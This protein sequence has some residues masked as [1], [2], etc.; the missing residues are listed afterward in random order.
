MKFKSIRTPL[1][2]VLIFLAVAPLFAL[3]AVVFFQ[4]RQMQ[5]A[6]TA[7]SLKMAYTDLDHTLMG[8]IGMLDVENATLHQSL[9]ANLNVARDRLERVGKPEFSAETVRWEAKNQ[10]SGE[11]AAI[12]LPRMSVG[13]TWLGQNADKS[14]PTPIVDEIRSL[15][16]CA[17][18]IFQRINGQGDMLRVATNVETL[19]GRR[20]IGTF[21]PAVGAGGNADAVVASVLRGERYVGRA[22]VVNAWYQAAYDPLYGADGSVAGMLFVGVKQDSTGKIREQ[23]IKTR[24]GKTGYVFVLDT[25]GSYVISQDGK[26]DGERIWD[27]KD[28]GGRFFIQEMIS[29]AVALK[30]GETAEQTYSWQNPGDPAPREKTVR[31]GYFQPW[32]WVIGAGSYTDEFMESTRN[33]QSIGARGNLFILLA[34]AISIVLSAG[35]SIAFTAWF[36]RPIV[37]TMNMLQRTAEGDLDAKMGER[38][39]LRRD[40]IGR[41]VGA[42]R[43]MAQILS[44]ITAG[45]KSIADNVAEGAGR[46]SEGAQAMS[47]SASMQASLGQQVSASMEEMGSN[48]RQN[49]E[50]AVQTSKVALKAADDVREG[51]KTVS[52]T[53][54]AMKEIA[55]KTVII[56]EIARQ[57]NL[58]ALNAAIEAARAGEHGKGFAVVAAEVRKLAERSQS[59]AA[60]I[61]QLSQTSVAVSE[62]AGLQLSAIVADMRKTADLV[63]E[64][65]SASSEQNTGAEQINKAIVQLDEAIQ[66]NA[67]SAEEFTATSEGLKAQVEEMQKAVSFFKA[68]GGAAPE[69]PAQAHALA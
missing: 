7:E 24:I 67:Q 20:A 65:A 8:V 11:V 48:I 49:S 44:S 62:K 41:L 61:G 15:T 32:N 1:M 28:S 21:I 40:E 9:S 33:I 3:W 16:G 37:S 38:E 43:R 13:G 30:A 17:A 39:S 5:A 27:S 69:L 6:A 53:A 47:D 12:D 46:V 31:I 35:M 52:D 25:Q 22:F 50:N 29:K 10:I 42:A 34:I 4:V 58:L 57:T 63:Q 64:I 51:G 2:L 60:E 19:E 23:I 55:G 26:R 56:E 36:A 14:A 59:A 54:A 68:G 45:I 18:T 66:R